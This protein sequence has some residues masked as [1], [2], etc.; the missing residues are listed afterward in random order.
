[1]ALPG[2]FLMACRALQDNDPAQFSS[3]A[4]FLNSLD[5][6]L[7]SPLSYKPAE[8][9]LRQ[10]IWGLQITFEQVAECANETLREWFRTIILAILNVHEA[11]LEWGY[12]VEYGM[13]KNGNVLTGINETIG[14]AIARIY[15]PPAEVA[16][17]FALRSQVLYGRSRPKE[18]IQKL[19]QWFA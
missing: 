1:M 16:E 9:L 4:S 5:D 10:S 8:Q 6:A 17:W 14:D 3:P 19:G 7:A 12:A 2:R 11:R 18:T 13:P 15:D